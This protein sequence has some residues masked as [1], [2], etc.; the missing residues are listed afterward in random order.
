MVALL[1]APVWL[2]LAGALSPLLPGRLR[3]LRLL[4]FVAVYAALE[5]SCLVALFG[6][7]LGTGFGA[8]VQ[9]PWAQ[10]AHY[11]IVRWFLR[12]L[13]WEARRVLHVRIVVEG[14]PP[15]EYH[16]RPLVVMARHAG[17]G[18]SFLVVHS[19]MNWYDREPRIVLKD[20][21][22]WDPAI[23]VVLNRL[24]NRFIS[25]VRDGSKAEQHIGELATGLDHNDALVIFPEGG[26]FTTARRLRAITRLRD[27]GHLRFAIRAER[28]VNVLPPRPGG[29]TAALRAAPNA[30]A[31]FVAHTGL[32]HLK[33]AGDL[34]RGLPMD[35]EVRMHW[36]QV[37]AGE[38]PRDEAGIHEWLYG[39]WALVDAW[40]GEHRPSELRR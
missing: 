24:P 8:A 31:V 32:E 1:S 37:P 38:V 12:V 27:L 6:L 30:D 18:D 22:Q 21:L 4:W 7:W 15:S 13:E 36:W 2:L 35:T 10:R 29:V 25:A 9:A 16:N 19:L 5:L 39:W 40:I 23:D 17:P 3:P 20:T 28:M 34:W 33:T 11:S 26:N 14:P